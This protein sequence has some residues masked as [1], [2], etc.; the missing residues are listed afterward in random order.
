M[1]KPVHHPYVP[2]ASDLIWLVFEVGREQSGRR[3]ALVL[4]PQ[5][6]TERTGQVYRLSDRFLKK[7]QRQRSD[8][9]T[10]NE[11]DSIDSGP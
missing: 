7:R 6:F 1:S 9:T 11:P 3:P 4:S 5:L 8:S 2:H 10:C